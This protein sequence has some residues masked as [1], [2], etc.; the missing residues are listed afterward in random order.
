[1]IIFYLGCCFGSFFTLVASRL[2]LGEDIIFSRSCCHSCQRTLSF[3][4]LIP[5]FSILI[6]RFRCFSCHK[7]I[8]I[9]YFF[10]E[11]IYGGLF[12]FSLQQETL[13][14]KIITLTW[15]TMAFLLSMTDYFY[16]IVEPKILYSFGAALWF[17]LFYYQ[18]PFYL[19]TGCFVFFCLL[20]V[21][22]FFQSYLGF[23]DLLLL[24]IWGPW[25]SLPQLFSLLAIASFSA[26]LVFFLY[27]LFN[28][29]KLA[30]IP[31]VP[32]L[33][34]GLFFIFI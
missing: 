34:F 18:F 6:S 4:E 9:F 23:G 26:L 10:S 32:F 5:L 29:K 33:S 22:F 31:F 16:L 14:L 2:P 1:M 15:L 8:P 7:R 17:L 25:L 24:L 20:L 19:W 28:Q 21:T 27:F 30:F 12:L 13:S 11:V 3:Y